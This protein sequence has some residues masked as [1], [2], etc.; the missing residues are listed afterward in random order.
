MSRISVI[1]LVTA[2][3]TS[4]QRR[5]WKTEEDVSTMPQ[6]PIINPNLNKS[7]EYNWVDCDELSLNFIRGESIGFEFWNG[8][9]EDYS[10][11]IKFLVPARKKIKFFCENF[12]IPSAGGFCVYD[13]RFREKR[14]KKKCYYGK[15][16]EVMLPFP[17][18]E[19]EARF[20]IE[21]KPLPWRTY[22]GQGARSVMNKTKYL[23]RGSG[24]KV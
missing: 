2:F 21:F 13:T 7:F 4:N 3:L 1:I 23:Y 20:I 14:G 16:Q 15:K 24:R 10:C 8:G 12:D 5:I 9:D 6:T 19:E 11:R 18:P 22:Q 17:E